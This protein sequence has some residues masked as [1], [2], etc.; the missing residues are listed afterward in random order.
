MNDCNLGRSFFI[1]INTII[2]E[3]E[4]DCAL[5]K[6]CLF[7]ESISRLGRSFIHDYDENKLVIA[8]FAAFSNALFSTLRF[9]KL[10][11]PTVHTICE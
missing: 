9:V 11:S 8:T 3:R 4:M 10:S 6:D 1:L 5:R 2:Q 7:M